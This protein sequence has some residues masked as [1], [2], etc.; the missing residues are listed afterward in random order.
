VSKSKTPERK[1]KVKRTVEAV[2]WASLAQGTVIV[3]KRWVALSAKERERFSELVRESRGR[4]KNLSVKQRLELRK[5][6][7]KLDLTGM[8]RELAL[9]LRGDKRKR[10]HKR[11]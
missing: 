7:R 5:L 4:L 10:S 1:S 9:L 8:S 6:A 2:P 11:R 3:G